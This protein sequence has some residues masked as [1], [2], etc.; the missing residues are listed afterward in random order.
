MAQGLDGELIRELLPETAARWRLV[1][2]MRDRVQ[3]MILAELAK[4]AR[5][6]T[7]EDAIR[8]AGEAGVMV[9]KTFEPAAAEG[10]K[11]TDGEL[12][13]A[14]RQALAITADRYRR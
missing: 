13:E 2:V 14:V 12:L 8:A 6:L 5:G 9:S 3:D 4:D 1:L 11:L 10:A 7:R